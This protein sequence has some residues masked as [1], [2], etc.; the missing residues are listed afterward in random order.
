MQVLNS[1]LNDSSDF[2][3]LTGGAGKGGSFTGISK[4][5]PFI[6]KGKTCAVVIRNIKDAKCQGGLISLVRELFPN[7]T[8]TSNLVFYFE[9][10]ASIVVCQPEGIIGK[11]FNA[12]F[13]DNASQ[14]DENYTMQ[15]FKRGKKCKVWFNTESTKCR[16]FIFEGIK[17]LLKDVGKYYIFPTFNNGKTVNGVSYYHATAMDN[18]EL[19]KISP[20]YLK[21]LSSLSIQEQ[22][23]LLYGYFV[24]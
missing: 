16:G 14:V 9:N 17:S 6:E 15:F 18:E 3:V 7:A 12:V 2:V 23:T 8:L 13:V 1:F 11:K 22:Y 5:K 10:G 4:F 20:D 19:L 24:K 21:L